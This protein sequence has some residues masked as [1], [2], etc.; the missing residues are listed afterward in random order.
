MASLIS[1]RRVAGL[2]ENKLKQ[3]RNG[4]VRNRLTVN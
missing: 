4:L 1:Q 3:L 2:Y